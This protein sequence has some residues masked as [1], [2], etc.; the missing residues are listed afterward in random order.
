MTKPTTTAAVQSLSANAFCDVVTTNI[1]FSVDNYDG[2]DLKCIDSAYAELIAYQAA[3]WF[4]QR[5]N[6]GVETDET[7][8]A[9]KTDRFMSYEERHKLVAAF[10]LEC[11]TA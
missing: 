9:L 1:Q 7:L 8:Q 5:F 6:M 3:C 11:A 10:H 4:A 2:A